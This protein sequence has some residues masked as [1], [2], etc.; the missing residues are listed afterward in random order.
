MKQLLGGDCRRLDSKSFAEIIAVET[1]EGEKNPLRKV[2]VK[3]M[4]RVIDKYMGAF[5]G[6]AD[7]DVEISHIQGFTQRNTEVCIAVESVLRRV[8]K[9]NGSRLII[10]HYK[11][12]DNTT[13]TQ[14]STSPS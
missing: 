7:L 3:V 11:C 8:C 5:V 6:N 12:V 14:M 10:A 13:I 2:L 9:I 4:Q 1:P